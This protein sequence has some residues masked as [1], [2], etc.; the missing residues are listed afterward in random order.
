MQDYSQG[1]FQR[2]PKADG[3]GP[4]PM[5]QMLQ[6]LMQGQGSQ[7]DPKMPGNGMPR[8]RV[9]KMEG[10]TTPPPERGGETPPGPGVPLDPTMARKPRGPGSAHFGPG[11][12]S[13]ARS[14][15]EFLEMLRGLY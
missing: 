10:P 1:G 5:M 15:E 7:R 3:A 2:V 12:G 8:Q 6:M 14:P 13:V 11:G 9:P 4:N